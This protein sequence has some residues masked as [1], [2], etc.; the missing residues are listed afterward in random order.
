MSPALLQ[1]AQNRQRHL[2][3]K[4]KAQAA[5]VVGLKG[6]GALLRQPGARA[7]TA[8]PSVQQAHCC[9]MVPC[10][11][12]RTWSQGW[13]EGAR[14]GASWSSSATER[15]KASLRP[16]PWCTRVYSG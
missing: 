6:S 12:L 1:S 9:C 14:T 11:Q 3:K 10:M 2:I 7:Q 15:S 5:L 4:S 13:S 8:R 16:K